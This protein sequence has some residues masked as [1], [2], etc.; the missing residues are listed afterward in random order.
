[1]Q[2]IVVLASGALALLALAAAVGMIAF[3]DS[4]FAAAL[5]RRGRAARAR[6]PAPVTPQLA[7]KLEKLGSQLGKGA[8]EGRRRDSLRMK[9]VR[10][11]FYAPRAVEIFY[12]VR[13]LSALGLG[14]AAILVA[15]LG[16]L[17]G[18]PG[19]LLFVVAAVGVGLFAPSFI[20]AQRTSARARAVRI[21]LPDAVDLMVVCVEAGGTLSSAMQRVTRQ[22]GDV[23]PVV[24]E[25]FQL[26]LL[27]M[28]AGSGRTEALER[29][30][31]RAPTDEIRS[32]AT[33]LIQSEALG[34]SIGHALRAFADEMRKSRYLE[35]ERKAGELPVKMAF[36]LVLGIFPALF[37]VIFVPLLIRF[38]RVS[39]TADPS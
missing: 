37:T 29:L 21:G 24:A 16:R 22:F 14:A 34:A 4:A 35:A 17:P 28:Q 7:D 2:L 33:L 32:M 13:V 11:G 31:A 20:V 19:V 12:A 6:T 38:L 18:S 1:M 39:L 27:E 36:P 3:N 10:A 25:L 5:A 26:M 15:V 8:L 9:M 23:H 30:A